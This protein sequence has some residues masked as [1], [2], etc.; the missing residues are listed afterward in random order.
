MEEDFSQ[1]SKRT[2]ADRAGHL[3]SICNQPTTC[4]DEDGKPFRIAD[5]AHIVGASSDGPRGDEPIPH[6]KAS[7]ENGIWLCARCHRK[8]DGDPKR[9][10]SDELRVFKEEAEERARRLVHGESICQVMDSTQRTIRTFFRRNALPIPPELRGNE[11]LLGVQ[12]IPLRLIVEPPNWEW[13]DLVHARTPGFHFRSGHPSTNAEG[14]YSKSF[15]E[16]EF[17]ALSKRGIAQGWKRQGLSESAKLDKG[18]FLLPKHQIITEILRFKK[19]CEEA[20]KVLFCPMYPLTVRLLL[21]NVKGGFFSY[22]GDTDQYSLS[23]DAV[24][25]VDQLEVGPRLLDAS[26]FEKLIED[27]WFSAGGS[28]GLPEETKNFISS[29]DH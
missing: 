22:L 28:Y 12:A 29:F 15:N 1:K 5:A 13:S 23:P 2:L 24:I 25:E 21:K 3:C 11:Y 10:T 9:Y 6:E 14:I 16:A 20:Y 4:S 18:R 19:T 17:T 27:V 8:I 26:D 7:P